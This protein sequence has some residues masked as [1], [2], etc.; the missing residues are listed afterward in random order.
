MGP[1]EGV[2]R[3][4]RTNYI[5]YTQKFESGACHKPIGVR[6]IKGIQ[7]PEQKALK[8]DFE[9]LILLL[10]GHHSSQVCLQDELFH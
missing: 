7:E 2:Q 8:V 1:L 4:R 3:L 10:E 6:A 5:P 9:Q